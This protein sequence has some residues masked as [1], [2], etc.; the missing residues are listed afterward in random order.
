MILLMSINPGFG[1]QKFED[2]TYKRIKNL[3]KMINEQ[4]LDTRIEV[5][6]GV[7]DQNIQKLVEA[8]ADTFVA[9]SHVFKS[10][11]PTATIKALKELANS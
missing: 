5:D 7:T 1:G 8:G 10:A 11:N 2:I 9:G 3:R 4:G 6:G